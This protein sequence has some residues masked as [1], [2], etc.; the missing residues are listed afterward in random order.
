MGHRSIHVRQAGFS[1]H[2]ERKAGFHATPLACPQSQ[3]F[4]KMRFISFVSSPLS[5]KPR[6]RLLTDG[7]YLSRCE[8]RQ[9]FM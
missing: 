5:A 7:I 9:A 1:Q 8:R 2:L 3:Q 4:K 6:R